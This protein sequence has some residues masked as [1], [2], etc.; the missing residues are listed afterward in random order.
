[1]IEF[2]ATRYRQINFGGSQNGEFDIIIKGGIVIDGARL[3]RYRADVAS[4]KADFE[5]FPDKNQT[6]RTGWRSG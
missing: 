2:G 4:P 3:P 6:R 1:L 5:R